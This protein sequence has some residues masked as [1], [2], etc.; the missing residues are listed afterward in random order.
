MGL[1]YKSLLETLSPLVNDGQTGMLVISGGFGFKAKLYLRAGCVFHAECGNLVGERA[2]RFI[3]KHKALM[4]LFVPDRGPEE[5]AR[6]RFSTD[7]VLYLFKQADRIWHILHKSISGYNA[8][9]ELAKGAQY[10]S[11]EITHRKVLSALDGCRTIHQVIQDTDVA[12]MDVLHVIFFYSGLGLVRPH[13]PEE[14]E[15]SNA[16]R[17]FM[18]K[19]REELRRSIPP[20]MAPMRNPV[21]H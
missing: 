11:V 10:D 1:T 7:E 6:T 18:S 2:I 4:T 16:C 8:V 19:L 12:E 13:N 9:F 20:S 14:R 17:E 21:A 15:A 3:A 5:V